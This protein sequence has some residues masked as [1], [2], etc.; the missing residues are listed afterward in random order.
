MYLAKHFWSLAV[1]AGF[2]CF[3]T[4]NAED[5]VAPATPAAVKVSLAKDGSL[6]GF[7]FFNKNDRQKPVAAKV[8]L[9]ADG[10]T[11]HTGVTDENG[12]FRIAN[13]EPGAYTM[14]GAG[15]GF[16]GNQEIL[17]GDASTS[18]FS[19]VPFMVEP[20]T[21][22]AYDDF[23]GFPADYVGGPVGGCAGGC[24]GGCG[25]SV[26]AGGGCGGS[27]GSCGGGCGGGFG[28]GVA[29]GGVRRLLP[30]VGL[31]GLAGL[32]GNDNEASPDE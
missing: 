22:V 32:G 14:V 10:K 23:A 9:S 18:G 13:V 5:P 26:V 11:V 17:V 29:G 25:G 27:C 15:E 12:S 21:A 16:V 4:A 31:V 20:S 28:G 3:S 2:F 6:N 30:L 19:Q 24:A 8:T 1:V 7:T